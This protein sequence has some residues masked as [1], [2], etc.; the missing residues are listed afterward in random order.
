MPDSTAAE[1]PA[2][3]ASD[4]TA[5]RRIELTL[6]KPPLALY[7]G[8]RPTV[9]IAGRGQPAQWGHGT[10]Q[11]PS[12]ETVRIGVFLFNRLWRFGRAEVALTPD[13]PP[14]LAYRAPVLPFFR[15]RFVA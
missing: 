3:T 15:G 1:N 4:T 14:A 8:V 6:R 2:S 13:N 10:W 9:V 12:G 5:T 11:V 7:V